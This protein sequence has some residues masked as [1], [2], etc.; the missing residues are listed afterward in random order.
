[1]AERGG[2][3]RERGGRERGGRERRGRE[4]RGERGGGREEE[5]GGVSAAVLMTRRLVETGS[6]QVSATL[7]YSP[8]IATPQLYFPDI[9]RA[10][11]R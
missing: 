3:R 8:S 6:E 2:G 10:Q 5:G 1:M 7:E 4:R 9:D 11:R